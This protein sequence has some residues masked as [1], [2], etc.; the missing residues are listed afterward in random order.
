MSSKLVKIGNG[1]SIEIPN[2]D[3]VVDLKITRSGKVN[4]QAP[5]ISPKDLCKLLSNLSI[6]VM[7]ANIQQETETKEQS[8]V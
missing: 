4:L 2:D 6:D 3:V 5:L 1:S 8:S 7:F